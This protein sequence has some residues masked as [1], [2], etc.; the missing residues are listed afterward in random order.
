V[1][2]YLKKS[3]SLPNLERSGT[4]LDFFPRPGYVK[5]FL[6]NHYQNLI[7][8]GPSIGGNSYDPF[9]AGLFI[10][11][12][13]LP[14]NNFKFFATPMYAFASK[15]LVGI[16]K[17]DYSFFP[18]NIVRKVNLFLNGSAFT[19]DEYTDSAGKK[20]YLGFQKI[21]PGIRFTFRQKDPRRHVRNYIQWKTYFINEDNLSFSRDTLTNPPAV[22][23]DVSKKTESRTV[24]QLLLVTENLRALYPYKGELK[25]EQSKDFVRLAFTGNYFF[26][27]PKSGGLEVRLFAG[28]F[29]YT[30]SKTILK[31]FSTER[32]HLNLSGAN[33][34]QDYTFSDYFIGRN[35][36]EGLP[37][38]QM[39]MRDGGFKAKTDLLASPVGQ[40]DDWLIS[41]NLASTI[42]SAINPLE[43]LPFK[44]PLKVFLDIGTYADAWKKDAEGDK[45][46]FD[47]GFQISLLKNTVNIY[48]PLIYSSVYK[49]YIQSV[50][51]D[52]NRFL[53]KISFSIDIANFSLKKIERN[54]PFF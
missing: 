48:I 54:L 23:T 45:F 7:T 29:I 6:D 25:I 5:N 52:K 9:M 43:L 46:L 34:Y 51:D 31:E 3:G 38:Q 17:L 33:G 30:A 53:K 11:N 36:F 50:I 12:V 14:L 44:I 49:D 47:G 22:V 35:K 27:Y 1:S 42:P 32:Y 18:H 21:V 28:K 26:N 24:N 8:V 13:K 20:T 41:T 4:K 2:A 39:M 40:T 15:R 10:T 37:S 19:V 16:G